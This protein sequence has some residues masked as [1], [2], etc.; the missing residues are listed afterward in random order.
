M[1]HRPGSGAQG[2]AV[3]PPQL[4]HPDRLQTLYAT[5]LLDSP[6]D[7]SFDRIT[8]LAARSLQAPTALIT[9]IAPERQFFL[10]HLGL[11]TPW[12]ELRQTPLSHSFCQHVVVANAPL[13]VEDARVHPLLHDNLAIGDLGVIAYAG[14]PLVAPDGA[15]LGALCVIDHV[16]RR[17]ADD[18]VAVLDDLSNT[19]T[20]ELRLRQ[21]LRARTQS[22]Q[23]LSESRAQLRGILESAMDAIITVDRDQRI[24]L[25]NRT[26]EQIFGCV[27]STALGQ[28]LARFILPES[29]TAPFRTPFAQT[30]TPHSLPSPRVLEA[31]RADGRPFPIEASISQMTVRGEPF[32]TMILRDISHRRELEAQLLHAQRL[33]SIGRLAGGI[34]HDFNNLLMAIGGCA[35][36]GLHDLPAAHPAYEELAQIQ[37]CVRRG[38]D[39]TRQLLAFARK[40]ASIP[41]IISPNQLIRHT[42]KLL[43]RLLDPAITCVM[44]LADEVGTVLIDPGHLEQVLINLAVNASDAMPA[45]GTLT[46]TTTT[47]L[48]DELSAQGYDLVPGRYVVVTVQDTG[49]G[50][51]PE[52][53]A[54][55]FEPFFTTKDPGQGTGLGLATCYGL[56][57]QHHGAIAVESTPGQG[58]TF[59]VYL[60]HADALAHAMS[61]AQPPHELEMTPVGKGR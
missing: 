17:W 26:A 21:E 6:P 44:Q 61:S 9:L 7:T 53:Q 38:S 5:R 2:A 22:E 29:P 28:P 60:P 50:I 49:S 18:V 13:V 25:F 46:I 15:T 20:A 58:A 54:H 33:E 59:T 56:V 3:A 1:S 55:L 10:S 12:A 30:E 42:A 35:S 23:A 16:P 41:H 47:A 27:A 51:D 45:G 40:Q 34:A 31:L 4:D 52:I 57:K 48:L 36:L 32:S 43:Q 39:L 14:V 8:R 37:G 24:V 19:I 11:R